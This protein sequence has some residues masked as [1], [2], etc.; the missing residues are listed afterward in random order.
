M[1]CCGKPTINGQPGAYSWDGKSF[2]TYP[3]APP[4]LGERDTLLYDEPGRCG[5]LD[6]HS[7]H[8][9]VVK[10]LGGLYS[11]LVRHGGGDE[12]I[13]LPVTFR[14]FLPTIDA[15]ESNARYWLLHSLYSAHSA[16]EREGTEKTGARYRQAFAEGRLKKRKVRGTNGF[17]IWIEPAPIART[18]KA[19]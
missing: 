13:V 14:L 9:R 6:A 8:F 16:A 5:G 4:A 10:S 12:R 11:L 7:H 15:M 3:P 19:A 1:C 2:S 17:K 18:E